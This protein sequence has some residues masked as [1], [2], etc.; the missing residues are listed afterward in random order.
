MHRIVESQTQKHTYELE[1]NGWLERVGVEPVESS[2]VFGEEHVQ[3]GIEDGFGDK[4]EI[5]VF[6]SS[7]ISSFLTNK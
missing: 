7:L 6:D 4:L 2:L 5:L 3:V 1:T